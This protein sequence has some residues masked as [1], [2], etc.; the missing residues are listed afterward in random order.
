[1]EDA[2]SQSPATENRSNGSLGAGVR[3]RLNRFNPNRNNVPQISI[4]GMEEVL[5]PKLD[6]GR[7]TDTE[8]AWWGDV[9]LTLVMAVVTIVPYFV[10]LVEWPR[11]EYVAALFSSLI[12]V[13]SLPMRREHP[14]RMM[15][16]VA[17]GAIIQF[18]F[19][20]FPVLS[21]FV[22]PIASYSVARWV[23]GRQSRWVLWVGAAGSVIGP[24]RWIPTIA[25]G[26]DPSSGTPWVL[27]VL[28]M[29]VC[30]GL[31]LTPYAVGRRLRESALLDSQQRIVK[32]QRYRAIL[33]EREQQAR[34]AE[35][36]TRN[37]IARELHDIVAHSLSVMIVQA[38]GGKALAAKKP[39][40]A[41]E[42]LDTIAETGREA[43]LEMRR[44]VGVLRQDTDAEF[45]PSPGLAEIAD[46]VEKSGVKA[47]LTVIG[48]EPVVP[49][50]LGLVVYRVVQEALTN[51]LKHAG[52]NAHATVTLTYSPTAIQAEILDDGYGDAVQG[53]GRGHGLQGMRERVTSMGGHLSTGPRKEGGFRVMAT[54]PVP[55]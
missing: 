27:L 55:A 46:L 24:M 25:A 16:L 43:L 10:A 26:Y 1:M 38:E 40:K 32:A 47:E 17:V 8:R 33:A 28:A 49:Q 21:I 39:E 13:A 12:M 19:V 11:P 9:T 31:V 18:L 44:I 23:D 22:V 51:V 4:P 14:L 35:E 34:V 15:S 45:S 50:A 54:L 30:A 3:A 2:G 36:R 42:V 7:P 52:R 48:D 29:T 6:D 41:P 20:P 53:D 5:D 37:E